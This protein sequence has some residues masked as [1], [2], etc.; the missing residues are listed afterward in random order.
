MFAFSSRRAFQCFPALVSDR[1]NTELWFRRFLVPFRP[2]VCWRHTE[3][4][5]ANV[6]SAIHFIQSVEK[7]EHICIY[8]RRH[9]NAN[10]QPRN[11]KKRN[12]LLKIINSRTLKIDIQQFKSIPHVRIA[13]LAHTTNQLKLISSEN[14]LTFFMV[15]FFLVFVWVNLCSVIKGNKVSRNDVTKGA[16]RNDSC[17]MSNWIFF[18]FFIFAFII[19]KLE[20]MAQHLR[21]ILSFIWH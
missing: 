7:S 14:N 16:T 13:S 3:N 8:T 5:S 20:I 18:L 21:D 6:Y 2:F 19:F 11:Q 4:Y 1:P 15:I 12:V 10:C 9:T 17:S